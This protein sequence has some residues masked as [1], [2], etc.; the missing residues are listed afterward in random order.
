MKKKIIIALKGLSKVGKTSTIRKVY[1]QLKE[2]YPNF[3]IRDLKK[4]PVNISSIIIIKGV[5]VGIESRGNPKPKRRLSESLKSFVKI[6]CQVIICATRTKGETVKAVKRLQGAYE[7][8]WIKKV[9][10]PYKK[11]ERDNSE[12]AR[13][14][15]RQIEK[16][17]RSK[18]PVQVRRRRVN[19]E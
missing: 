19:I 2:K 6:G 11:H 8:L 13:E 16:I 5:K 4:L 15:I 3:K 14:I 12:K 18:K 7:I 10:L 9:R 1:E 17:I